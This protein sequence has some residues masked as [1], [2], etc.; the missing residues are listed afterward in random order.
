MLKDNADDIRDKINSDKENP[1][2]KKY[3]KNAKQLRLNIP[4][5]NY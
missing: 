5:T 2:L 4:A 3:A 1:V